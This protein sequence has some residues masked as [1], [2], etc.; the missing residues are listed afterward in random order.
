MKTRHLMLLAMAMTAAPVCFAGTIASVLPATIDYQ[1][2][3]IATGIGVYSF[4]WSQ[5]GSYNNVTIQMA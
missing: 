1:R 2:A 5:T 3:F 4:G